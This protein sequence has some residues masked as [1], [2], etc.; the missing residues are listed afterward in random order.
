MLHADSANRSPGRRYKRNAERWAYNLAPACLRLHLAG[1]SCPCGIER[2][3]LTV[4]NTFLHV[5]HSLALT[6]KSKDRM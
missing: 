2:T 3:R 4:H 5:I 1:K 6:F